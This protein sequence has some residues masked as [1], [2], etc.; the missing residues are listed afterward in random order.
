VV[1]NSSSGLY[2]APTLKIPAV[3]IGS[4]QTG[5]TRAENVVDVDFDKTA[6]VKTIR[7]VLQDSAYR[8]KLSECRTPYGDGHATERTL[9]ILRR[10]I[11]GPALV[12][13][14]RNSVGPFLAAAVDAA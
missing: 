14:W 1:G 6:I 4:R 11:L 10:L 12:A 2:D 13:K 5:R 7:F 8:A 9:D 3:N